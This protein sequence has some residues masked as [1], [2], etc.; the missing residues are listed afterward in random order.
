MRRVLLALGL[1]LPLAACG[2]SPK[3]NFHTLVA[4][5]PAHGQPSSSDFGAPVQVGDVSLPESL[6]RLAMVA[7]GP[8]TR[9]NVMGDDRWVAPLD[10]LI[11]RTLSDDLRAR[12]G[13]DNVLAPGEPA[14]KG[15]A[16]MLVLTV[17]RFDGTPDGQV[18]L[19]ADWVL[20]TAGPSPHAA[21]RQH[22]D[23]RVNAGG[24]S[25]DAVAAGMSKALGELAD[26]IAA[27]ISAG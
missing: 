10:A 12:L 24:T 27:A 8:G 4:V 16:R 2:G 3:T 1:V 22:V 11:R 21:D 15:G 7:Q 14:P 23:L 9:V 25:A 6:D 17:Q 19:Q 5:P 13:P 18:V 20:G 26:R